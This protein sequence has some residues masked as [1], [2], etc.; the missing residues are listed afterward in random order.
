[1]LYYKKAIQNWKKF[2]IHTIR[3]HLPPY[4]LFP[5]SK[6]QMVKG[7]NSGPPPWYETY[8]NGNTIPRPKRFP[9]NKPICTKFLVPNCSWLTRHL[10]QSMPNYFEACLNPANLSIKRIRKFRLFI[11][12]SLVNLLVFAD[13]IKENSVD[14][15]ISKRQ[16]PQYDQWLPLFLT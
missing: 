8:M 2:P 10:R 5:T 16:K 15:L 7:N 11:T 1:M 3:T 9:P 12:F 14:C 4:H 13:K 6:R